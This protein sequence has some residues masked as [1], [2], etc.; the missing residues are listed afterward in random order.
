MSG[1]D[2]SGVDL[3]IKLYLPK[4]YIVA[5][6]SAPN[7]GLAEEWTGQAFQTAIAGMKS[8]PSQLNFEIWVYRKL[9]R[10]LNKHARVYTEIAEPETSVSS[11]RLALSHLDG[12]EKTM[13][14]MTDL[15]DYAPEFTAMACELKPDKIITEILK[16]RTKISG[17]I[18]LNS[19]PKPIKTITAPETKAEKQKKD[20]D[21][22]FDLRP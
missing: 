8:I 22:E 4:V 9:I 11:A 21:T 18:K 6:Y 19:K 17:M 20:S 5:Y 1:I 14:L 13:I 3:L 7:D 2:G 15:L 10:I 12:R 16:A